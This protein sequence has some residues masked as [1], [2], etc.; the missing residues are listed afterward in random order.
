MTQEIAMLHDMSRCT[1]CRGCM[2]ACKHWHDLDPDMDTPFEGQY[3][4]HD[5]LSPRLYTLIEMKEYVDEAGTF[6]WEFFKKNCFH[7]GNPVCV[8]VCPRKAIVQNSNGTVVIQQEQCVGCLMCERKC[9]WH[10]PKIDGE[11]RKA[12]KCD[13]CYDRIAHGYETN[14]DVLKPACAKTCAAHALEF[15]P[16]EEIKALAS[17]RLAMIQ[18]KYPEASIYSPEEVGGTH[19]IYVLPYAPTVFGLPENPAIE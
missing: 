19:M 11:R 15:G 2:V 16:I 3:Q 18:D 17:K 13:L 9:P 8:S 10:I 6:R 5:D 1:A 12:Y 4:S 7:C 14:G